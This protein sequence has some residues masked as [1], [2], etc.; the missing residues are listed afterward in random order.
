MKNVLFF[1]AL[2]FFALVFFLLIITLHFRLEEIR[3]WKMLTMCPST[4]NQ[5]EEEAGI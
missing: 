2:H 1:L 3:T 5:E 4:Y